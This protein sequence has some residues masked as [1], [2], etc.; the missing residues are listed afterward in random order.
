MPTLDSYIQINKQFR[1]E[2][3]TIPSY[4]Y[5]SWPLHFKTT[6]HHPTVTPRSDH[7]HDYTTALSSIPWNH[8][9]RTHLLLPQLA[10]PKHHHL[11]STHYF[12]LPSTQ[13][14]K[15]S[16]SNIALLPHTT[17]SAALSLAYLPALTMK[18]KQWTRARRSCSYHQYRSLPT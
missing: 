2:P 1:N 16:Y 9:H 10:P 8:L 13:Y 3:S 5:L 15:T 6:A 12:N 18:F 11:N 17:A 14:K 4:A 7:I